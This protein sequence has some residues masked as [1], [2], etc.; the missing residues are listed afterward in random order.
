MKLENVIVERPYKK[1]YRCE[2]GIAKVFE[3]THPK[4][5]VFNEALNQARVEATGLNIP[6]V[7]SVNEIDGK[8][9]LVIEY[10]EGKTLEELMAEPVFQLIGC[11][12]LA[13]IIEWMAGKILERLNQHKWLGLFEQEMEF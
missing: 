7:K 10:K 13:T 5:D 12:V 2:E 4:E 6:K 1:V 11:G 3:P 8:W 9:A